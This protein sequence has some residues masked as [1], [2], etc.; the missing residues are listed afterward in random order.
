[1]VVD[2]YNQGKHSVTEIC[3][4]GGI[5][6]PTLYNYVEI[7]YFSWPLPELRPIVTGTNYSKALRI[8]LAGLLS[9]VTLMA[10]GVPKGDTQTCGLTA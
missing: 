10:F 1:M 5:T 6:K 3:R 8:S 9:F 4:I 2:L 7:K